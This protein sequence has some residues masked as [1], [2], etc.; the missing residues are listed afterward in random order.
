MVCPAVMPCG[1]VQVTG[2]HELQRAICT[3]YVRVAQPQP[4]KNTGSQPMDVETPEVGARL[5]RAAKAWRA[6][7]QATGIPGLAVFAANWAARLDLTS[8]DGI[9]GGLSPWASS[10][11]GNTIPTSPAQ[12]SMPSTETRLRQWSG[13]PRSPR[14]NSADAAVSSSTGTRQVF[15]AFRVRK[16]G[17][18]LGIITSTPRHKDPDPIVPLWG[19]AARLSFIDGMSTE[20]GTIVR[21]IRARGR[22]CPGAVGRFRVALTDH[23][24][25]SRSR[26]MPGSLV[27]DRQPGTGLLVKINDLPG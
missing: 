12:L 13:F 8:A 2:L 16:G 22:C 24:I 1:G 7:G 25:S 5:A 27:Q 15:F 6:R 4:A 26:G 18:G 23:V 20:E 11:T 17:V 10:G 19:H 9:L 14:E 3:P 21:D